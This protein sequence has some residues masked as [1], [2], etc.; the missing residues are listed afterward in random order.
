[1]STRA[2][3]RETGSR[4]H[5][6]PAGRPY[7]SE[8][9]LRKGARFR[10]RE[11]LIRGGWAA[12]LASGILRRV[13]AGRSFASEFGAIQAAEALRPRRRFKQSH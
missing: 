6:T 2:A 3:L 10:E 5:E 1:M 9:R 4:T 8:G 12:M 11:G 7:D 13:H